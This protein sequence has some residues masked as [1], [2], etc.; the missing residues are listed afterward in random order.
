M[1]KDRIKF[2]T[3]DAVLKDGTLFNE[4]FKGNKGN[5]MDAED[6]FD[7]IVS[8]ASIIKSFTKN[9]EIDVASRNG[10]F[11]GE[12]WFY[13]KNSTNEECFNNATAYK[14]LVNLIDPSIKV[15]AFLWPNDA[16][17]TG[18][19]VIDVNFFGYTLN[20]GNS[21]EQAKK[22]EQAM[23]QGRKLARDEAEL[24][25]SEAWKRLKKEADAKESIDATG[26]YNSGLIDDME[27]WSS[28][29]YDE[30]EDDLDFGYPDEDE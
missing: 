2:T 23:K 10:V 11:R 6:I 13:M 27:R 29:E 14:V 3:R 16:N 7:K 9:V 28:D 5:D 30:D 19:D 21:E 17:G 8:I 20:T 25:L 4:L 1:T 12:A 18:D 26:S 24:C 15:S 22:E